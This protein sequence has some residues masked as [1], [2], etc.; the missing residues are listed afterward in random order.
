M[1]KAD[2][3]NEVASST[4]L[5]KTKSSE[6][7]DAVFNAIGSTLSKGEKVSLAGFGNWE[8]KSKDAR[9]ARNPKTGEEVQV[10]SKTVTKF[11]PGA[12]L[13]KQIN[14]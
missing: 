7:I 4:G 14:G 6:V 8:T 3:I 11:K 2:L 9:I 12:A 13:N 1:N 5:S 10:P